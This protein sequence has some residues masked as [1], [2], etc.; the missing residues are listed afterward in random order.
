MEI[1]HKG[2]DIL[3]QDCLCYVADCSATPR[4]FLDGMA[5][6]ANHMQEALKILAEESIIQVTLRKDTLIKLLLIGKNG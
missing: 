6:C 5:F 4:V 2:R 3:S 1:S